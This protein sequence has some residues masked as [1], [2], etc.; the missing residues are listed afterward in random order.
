MVHIF[1]VLCVALGRVLAI[2]ALC[3]GFIYLSCVLLDNAI[4]RAGMTGMMLR[5]CRLEFEKDRRGLA[6]R[7][8]WG[9]KEDSDPS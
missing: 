9:R 1:D 7:M 6:A 8:F 4:R 2:A 3:A 5:F